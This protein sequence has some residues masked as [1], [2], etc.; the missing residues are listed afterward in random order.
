M[1]IV[2]NLF[3][4]FKVVL[5]KDKATWGREEAPVGSEWAR[6]FLDPRL[7]VQEERLLSLGERRR[8]CQALQN[9]VRNMRALHQICLQFI[10]YFQLNNCEKAKIDIQRK[11][12]FWVKK[13]CPITLQTDWQSELGI[14]YLFTRQTILQKISQIKILIDKYFLQT[15]GRG[16]FLHSSEDFIPNIARTCGTL[17]SGRWWSLC[18]LEISLCQG[19]R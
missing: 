1:Q 18:Q 12:T 13:D 6:G 15:T 7:G 10:N 11:I 16:R 3:F 17:Q 19:E 9:Q 4:V 14:F 2:C 5:W 8:Y